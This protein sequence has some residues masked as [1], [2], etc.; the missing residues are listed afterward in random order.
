PPTTAPHSPLGTPPM[1]PQAAPVRAVSPPP[2][3]ATR[4][5]PARAPV[6]G[7]TSVARPPWTLRTPQALFPHADPA[8]TPPDLGDGW[9]LVVEE[10]DGSDPFA[11]EAG[12]LLQNMLR[13]LRLHRHPRVFLCALQTPAPTD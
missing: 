4:T 10:A 6:T 7:D 8:H 3:A 5:V 1:A 9:L 13:A 12:R 2:A 11:G